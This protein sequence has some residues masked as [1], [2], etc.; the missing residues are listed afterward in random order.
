MKYE[1]KKEKGKNDCKS[2]IYNA[3]F[4]VVYWKKEKTAGSIEAI[5]NS[6]MKCLWICMRKGNDRN[7][8]CIR[9]ESD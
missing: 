2:R 4:A 7:G 8:T 6:N 9:G 3:S 5:K 1:F